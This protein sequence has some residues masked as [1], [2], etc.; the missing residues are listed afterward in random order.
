MTDPNTEAKKGDILHADNNINKQN[1]TP[2]YIIYLK[3]HPGN[4][5]LFIGALLTHSPINGNVALQKDH[6]VQAD[7]NGNEYKIT[8]NN[9][10]VI[11]HPIYK[12]IDWMP[13]EKVGQLTPKGIEFIEGNIAPYEQ[14]F[15]ANNIE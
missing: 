11:N 13:F 4:E 14:Q 15:I 8:F 12:K 5:H 9:S 10:L 6:F 7:Q 2:H 1:K 3:P